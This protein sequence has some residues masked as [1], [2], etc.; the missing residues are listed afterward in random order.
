MCHM[1]HA[2]RHPSG[3]ATAM[4][5]PTPAWRASDLPT[6]GRRR[7]GTV[8]L[9]ERRLVRPAALAGAK[10]S[11]FG[12][13]AGRVKANVLPPGQPRRAGRPAVDASR[14]HRIVEDA[15]STPITPHDGRPPVLVKHNLRQNCRLTHLNGVYAR[16]SSEIPRQIGVKCIIRRSAARRHTPSRPD[17][18]SESGAAPDPPGSPSTSDR[19]RV[20]LANT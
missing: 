5:R 11:Q 15:V 4:T 14:P 3:A 10:A 19:P 1:C 8:L 20:C 9:A 18:Q 17:C 7:G 6:T 16:T 12:R 13:L 2:I